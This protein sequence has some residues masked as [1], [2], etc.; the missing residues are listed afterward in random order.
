MGP[1]T[2][3]EIARI[4]YNKTM[5][6]KTM[7]TATDVSLLIVEDD[8][9]FRE[10]F[11]DA[12]ALQG[13]RVEA[14]RCGMD[15]I[16]LLQRHQPSLVI[17]DVQLPDIHGFELC[18]CIKKSERLKNIP[19]IFLSASTHYNDPRDRAE[20]LLAGA[21]LFLAKPIKVEKLW[22]EIEGVIASR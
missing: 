18:R 21:A 22:S 20:G 14:V 17:I 5:T 10:T 11:I 19:V 9:L 1:W 3:C 6:P 7:K 8:E 2:R 13:V 4:E 16:R 15:A 12:M